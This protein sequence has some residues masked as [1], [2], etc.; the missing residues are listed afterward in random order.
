MDSQSSVTHW[1]H[2]LGNSDESIAQEQLFHR[3]FQQLVGLA[4]QKLR[5]QSSLAGDGEDVAL[6]AMDSFFQRARRGDFPDLTS[7]ID[8]WALLVTITTRKAINEVHRQNSAKRRRASTT[9][10]LSG[11]RLA[12]LAADEPTPD[13]VA[14]LAEE[15]NQRLESLPDESLRQVAQLKLEGFTNTEIAQQLNI[16]E[17]TVGR[18]LFCIRREWSDSVE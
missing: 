12:W 17:R 5:R 6:S 2:R 10:R 1:L 14:E 7:R 13:L 9:Q 15:C 3:Y 16:A 18:K 4:S 11:D 8:L